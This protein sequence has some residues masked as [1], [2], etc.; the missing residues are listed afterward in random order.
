MEHGKSKSK[1]VLRKN[2]T[3]NN[4]KAGRKN[5]I[6]RKH[7]GQKHTQLQYQQ[8]KNKPVKKQGQ[9]YPQFTVSF[10]IYPVF[11]RTLGDTC[12]RMTLTM[13]TD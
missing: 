4:R 2:K 8:N 1:F 5:S 6:N 7:F 3:N 12:F 10:L 11:S 13:N 9:T